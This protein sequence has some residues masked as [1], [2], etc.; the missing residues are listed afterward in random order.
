MNGENFEKKI[1]IKNNSKG[2]GGQICIN[3]DEAG[4]RIL[5]NRVPFEALDEVITVFEKCSEMI[6]ETEYYKTAYCKELSGIDPVC[7]AEYHLS[8]L[9]H[10]L[11]ELKTPE[12]GTSEV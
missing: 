10:I 5:N 11:K 1:V 2:F 8:S 7:L 9:A 3:T 4:K 12:N 6:S